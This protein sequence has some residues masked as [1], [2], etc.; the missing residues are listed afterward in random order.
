[1]VFVVVAVVLGRAAP[2]S[3]FSENFQRTRRV[4]WR[5]G[6]RC[7]STFPRLT[8]RNLEGAERFPGVLV[9]WA[10]WLLTVKTVVWKER[11]FFSCRKTNEENVCFP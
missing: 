7:K 10:F 5:R 6:S 4:E 3:D 11:A 1:M 2:S 8:E 9:A